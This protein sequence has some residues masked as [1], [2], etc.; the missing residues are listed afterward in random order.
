M[1]RDPHAATDKKILLGR[2][3][4][5]LRRVVG[6]EMTPAQPRRTGFARTPQMVWRSRC[7]VSAAVEAYRAALTMRAESRVR[8]IGV[9][10][11]DVHKGNGTASILA[12]DPTVFTFRFTAPG[13]FPT[14][15][16]FSSPPSRLPRISSVLRNNRPSFPRRQHVG[17]NR[18]PRAILVAAAIRHIELQEKCDRAFRFPNIEIS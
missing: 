1:L 7:S 3:A 11:W 16:T 14:W 2:D 15:R 9:L 17:M 18:C 12:N 5:Y 6:G 10:D 13:I 8:R 4:A